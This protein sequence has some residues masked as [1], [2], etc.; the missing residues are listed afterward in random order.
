[1]WGIVREFIL[2]I[3]A[4]AWVCF[5]AMQPRY[6]SRVSIEMLSRWKIDRST[7]K[8]LFRHAHLRNCIAFLTILLIWA[9]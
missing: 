1:M 7:A 3:V 4:I 9:L 8:E 6:W 5:I 2:G